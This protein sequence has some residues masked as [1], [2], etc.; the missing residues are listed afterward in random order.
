MLIVPRLSSCVQLH[1][2]GPM[3]ARSAAAP[4]RWRRPFLAWL[5]GIEAGWAIPLLIVGF[6]AIWTL[7]LF[8]AYLSG[9]LHQDALETWSVGRSFQRVLM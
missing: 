3:A 9:D 5:D 6:A 4:A 2:I 8:I 1:L 7:F